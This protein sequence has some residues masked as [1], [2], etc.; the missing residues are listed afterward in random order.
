MK[1]YIDI[2]MAHMEVKPNQTL[3]EEVYLGMR[4]TIIQGHL[5][6]GQRINEKE[7]SNRAHI[8]R[9]PIRVAL[10]RLADERLIEYVTNVGAVVSQITAEDVEEIFD[11][12][13]VLDRLATFKAAENMVQADFDRLNQLITQ[14]EAFNAKGDVAAVI[15]GV[16]NFNELI[17]EFSNMP[18]L[19]MIVGQLR[20]YLK[21]LRDVSLNGEARRVKALAEHRQIYELMLE[22]NRPELG[23]LLA[24]HLTYSKTFILSEMAQNI[25]E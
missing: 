9:T 24:E 15:Q 5:L 12:R 19:V 11:I 4:K 10:H 22:K 6:S 20:D 13:I 23:Q 1:D 7:F 25:H 16:E 3:A 21:R 2:I 8:S 14:T 18:H 17:Y